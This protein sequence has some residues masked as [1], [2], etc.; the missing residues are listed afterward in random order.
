MLMAI[1]L[2][3][4]TYRLYSF[5][6]NFHLKS[7]RQSSAFSVWGSKITFREVRLSE[8]TADVR[9]HIPQHQINNFS[10]LSL[11]MNQ[12]FTEIKHS[13]WWKAQ[14]VQSHVAGSHR[15]GCVIVCHMCVFG[16]GQSCQGKTTFSGLFKCRN[17]SCVKKV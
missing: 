15:T 8:M 12:L 5:Q 16:C 1:L 14:Q 10:I 7:F 9:W 13:S 4:N 17:T 3:N 11:W 6:N 2:S